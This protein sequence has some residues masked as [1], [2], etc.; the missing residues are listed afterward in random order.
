[1]GQ[2]KAG[3]FADVCFLLAGDGEWLFHELADED[4]GCIISVLV[5]GEATEVH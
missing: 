5:V 4:E 2:E 1:M 3:K